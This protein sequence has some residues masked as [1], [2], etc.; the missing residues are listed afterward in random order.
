MC[1]DHRGDATSYDTLVLTI[2]WIG[3]LLNQR[4]SCFTVWACQ[5]RCVYVDTKVIA[6]QQQLFPRF[7]RSDNL[8]MTRTLPN[9]AH[10]GHWGHCPPMISS[11]LK[12]ATII[13]PIL[14]SDTFANKACHHPLLALK[15]VGGIVVIRHHSCL[16]NT[17]NASSSLVLLSS[18][19]L[20]L[21]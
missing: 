14:S 15:D 1:G 17:D 2:C 7:F 9:D 12:A 8:T 20:S 6:D 21:L 11:H 19:L 3:S 18:L 4:Y 13:S 10:P 16:D 5:W